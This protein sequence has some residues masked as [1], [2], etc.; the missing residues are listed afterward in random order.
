MW[1]VR[2]ITYH[3]ASQSTPPWPKHY[4][5]TNPAITATTTITTTT[6]TIILINKANHKS[7]NHRDPL[8]PWLH[9]RCW[10]PHKIWCPLLHVDPSNGPRWRKERIKQRVGRER[11]R[12]EKTER[13]GGWDMREKIVWKERRGSAERNKIY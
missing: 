1:D 7:N 2:I 13:K 6:T 10:C 12:W 9:H 5:T 8:P 11:M 3:Y 4:F